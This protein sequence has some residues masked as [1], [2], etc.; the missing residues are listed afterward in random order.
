[1]PAVDCIRICETKL[2]ENDNIQLEKLKTIKDQVT[3]AQSSLESKPTD[4]KVLS[5][6]YHKLGYHNIV[7]INYTFVLTL[8]FFI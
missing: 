4:L 7:F 2:P 1:M 5:F 8:S 6:R 3:K